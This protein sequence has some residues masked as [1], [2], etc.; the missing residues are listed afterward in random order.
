MRREGRT[1]CYVAVRNNKTDWCK[2]SKA[3]L[4]SISIV[5]C[6]PRPDRLNMRIVAQTFIHELGHNRGL[7]HDEMI[8][9][10]SIDASWAE[11]YQ[12]RTKTKPPR[13]II[14]DIKSQRYQKTL[15]KIKELESKQK[16]ITNLLKKYNKKKK[17]Y[18]RFRKS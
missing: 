4:N 11:S 3:W 13:P 15:A 2:G 18:E 1:S 8:N 17:Y 7:K 16:R 14:E 10:Y 9:S 5:M 6:I 12:L